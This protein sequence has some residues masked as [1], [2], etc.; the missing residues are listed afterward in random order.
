MCD[1]D[2]D[3]LEFVSYNGRFPT[4]CSGKLVMRLNGNLITFPDYCLDS[5]GRV[6]FDEDWNEKVTQG[7]WMIYHFPEGFPEHLKEKA[8]DL[9]NENVMYG[10]CGGCV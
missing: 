2:K 7:P 5:G 10:C 1:S 8:T 6:S 3:V 4:L 9:V